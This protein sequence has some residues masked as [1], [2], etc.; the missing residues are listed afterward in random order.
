MGIESSSV[1]SESIRL[2]Y[3]NEG[4]Y[5]KD[6]LFEKHHRL[7]LI[8]KRPQWMREGQNLS[9]ADLARLALDKPALVSFIDTDDLRLSPP[10]DMPARIR[11]ICRE[12]NQPVPEDAG[13][14]SRC[15]YESLALKYRQTKENIERVAN[16]TFQVL[17][18]VGGGS[19]NGLL[20]QFAANATGLPVI[21]GPVEATAI[22][23]VAVQLITL[24]DIADLSEA[25][26]VVSQ[27]FETKQY[28][29]SHQAAWDAAYKRYQEIFK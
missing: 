12:T 9:Y 19:Q 15:I 26:K 21:T 20:S 8:K 25:R 4:G 14:V 23:N 7:W 5:D 24:G 10:G 3:T 16:R 29:P 28:E 17:H 2:M 22:G 18:I 27:S 11:E 1:I 13:S 6:P